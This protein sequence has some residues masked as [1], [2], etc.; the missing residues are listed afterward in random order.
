MSAAAV[1]AT[2]VPFKRVVLK[3]SGESFSHAGERGISMD[4]VT[5][6][7]RQIK[8]AADAGCQIAIVVGGGNILR[9]VAVQSRATRASRKPPPTTW[10]CW[11]R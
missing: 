5:H 3:L 1:S 6:I 8:Q 7:A 2:R 9:G 11:P 4:E 10:A